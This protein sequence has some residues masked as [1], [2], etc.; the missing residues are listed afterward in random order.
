MEENSIYGTRDVVLAEIPFNDGIGAKYRPVIILED[1]ST[2]FA[3]CCCTSKDRTGKVAGK[4]IPKDSPENEV[5]FKFDRDTF[6]SYT[7]IFAIYKEDIAVRIGYCDLD[8]FNEILTHFEE[9]SFK[10]SENL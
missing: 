6:I 4:L 7:D 3:I 1:Q 5:F 9:S 2:K 10:A 8:T